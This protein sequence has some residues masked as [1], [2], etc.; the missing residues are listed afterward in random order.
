MPPKRS[1]L[2]IKI[3]D[4][5]GFLLD[6]VKHEE[7]ARVSWAELFIRYR[8]WFEAKGC[9]PVAADAFGARLDALRAELGLR[10]R[11][12]GKDVFFVDLKLAS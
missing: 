12:K 8:T 5:D 7:G 6:R 2:P 11:T 10:T 9:T 4:V 1:L 3:G